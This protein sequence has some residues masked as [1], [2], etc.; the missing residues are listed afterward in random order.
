MGYKYPFFL[1]NWSS[2]HCSPFFKKSVQWKNQSM[3]RHTAEA[4]RGPYL[5]VFVHRDTEHTMTAKYRQNR[6]C[7]FTG[8]GVCTQKKSPC[9]SRYMPEIGIYRLNASYRLHIRW[10]SLLRKPITR[11]LSACPSSIW[12]TE[13]GM[14]Q[15]NVLCRYHLQARR[16][17]AHRSKSR[18]S[19]HEQSAW[20]R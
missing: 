4:R 3:R 11:D 1:P 14:L 16:A 9:V 17:F 15:E 5:L 6:D 7:P 19:D 18:A 13:V 2:R 12:P 20:N 10:W 8:C